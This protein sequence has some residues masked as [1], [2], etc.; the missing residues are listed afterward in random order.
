MGNSY[1]GLSSS[2]AWFSFRTPR[3]RSKVWPIPDTVRI[4]IRK[5]DLK[6][7]SDWIPES[8]AISTL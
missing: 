3:Y 1:D 7:S 4:Q 6:R 2:I 8:I 5:V